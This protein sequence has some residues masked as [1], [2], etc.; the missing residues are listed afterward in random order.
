MAHV[1]APKAPVITPITKILINNRGEIARRIMRTARE[2]GIATVAVY[3]D[4]DNAAPFF[5]A[6]PSST[7]GAPCARSHS[8]AASTNAVATP[9]RRLDSSTATS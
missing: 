3:A 2:M 7:R 9:V 1:S 8:I 6:V 4:S 5:S